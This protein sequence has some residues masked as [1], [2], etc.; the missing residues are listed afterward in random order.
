MLND[1]VARLRQRKLGQWAFGY[2]AAAWLSYEV[3]TLI[4]QNF[5][6]PKVVLQVITVILGAGLAATLVLAWY[7]GEKGRQN[8][9]GPELLMLGAL[10]LVAIVGVGV[11]LRSESGAPGA[12]ASVRLS[13]TS[14]VALPDARTIAVLPFVNVGADPEQE[15]FSDGM[16]EELID[17]LAKVKGLRVASR[18]SAFQ[19]KGKAV[20]IP[21][22]ARQLRV[23]SVVEGSVRRAGSRLR[24]NARLINGA[25]GYEV[26][27]ETYDR[28]L[29]DVFK[30]QQ[31][32][33]RAI[34]DAL[35]VQL[36]SGTPQASRDTDVETYNTYLQAEFARR[37]GGL[38][39][40]R[41]SVMLYEQV[42]AR[43]SLYA[44]AYAGIAL[45]LN[46]IADDSLP[47]REAYPRAERAARTALRLDST[48][49]QAHGALAFSLWVY[50][51]KP[52]EAE[53]TYLHAIEM[54]PSYTEGYAALGRLY[55]AQR[56][57]GEAVAT[58]KEAIGRDPMFQGAHSQAA[59][60]LVGMK[61]YEQAIFE[62][63]TALEIAPGTPVAI[64]YLGDALLGLGRPADALATYRRGLADNP[65]NVRLKG[66]E[67]R[68]LVALGRRAEALEI[69]QELERE[70]ARRHV[71]AEEIAGIY[72]ALGDRVRAFR[73]LGRGV[74][75]HSAGM[76]YI[77]LFPHFDPIRS[78]PR[79]TTILGTVGVLD[80]NPATP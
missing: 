12:A 20:N 24:V 62:A 18:G 15:Y 39:N 49:V 70:S 23:G 35:K 45:A 54:N 71:R 31:E 37:R 55:G 64:R 53:R 79:F 5:E 40:L 80:A 76:A 10:L 42:L 33:S 3:L 16:T 21:D 67:G 43:D 59:H 75:D 8:V 9:S 34:V 74:E 58:L 28:E 22:A 27:S 13:D 38:S 26:W 4:G 73:W 77:E 72:V 57:F 65:G 1:F 63:G 47:P 29:Q 19:F 11:L 6:W 14:A 2:I 51:W 61:D 41:R 44:R 46:G 30:V 48:V 17:A 25:D 66:G 52:L 50:R 56:R 60:V 68:A 7:H 32:L 69:A 36:A 78:D